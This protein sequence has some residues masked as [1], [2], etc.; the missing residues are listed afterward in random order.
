[1]RW[2]LV[3]LLLVASS[4][5]AAQGRNC[6]DREDMLRG[7]EKKYGE[8]VKHVAITGPGALAEWTVAP[9]GSWSMLVTIPNG[10]TCM[11]AEGY[12]WE[13]KSKVN[14]IEGTRV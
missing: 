1:M 3:G 12:G 2:M 14:G 10:Q 6:G 4:S 9:D 7:L 5:V 11:M 13:D 8:V